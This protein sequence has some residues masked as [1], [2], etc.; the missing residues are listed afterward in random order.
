MDLDLKRSITNNV[1]RHTFSTVLKRSG[2]SSVFI[3]E[4]LGYTNILITENNLD[5]FE[6]EL[7]KLHAGKLTAFDPFQNSG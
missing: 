7:R 6:N 1:S 5:I 3:Q 2:V 4:S